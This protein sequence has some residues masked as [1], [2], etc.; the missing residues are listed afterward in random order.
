MAL[1]S[2]R[3]ELPICT[4]ETDRDDTSHTSKGGGDVRE[5]FEGQCQKATTELQISP[6]CMQY[7]FNL[8]T[9]LHT[10]YNAICM[11]KIML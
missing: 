6:L 11:N 3:S 2:R 7:K 4:A 9:R 1:K 10:T 8:T 5:A